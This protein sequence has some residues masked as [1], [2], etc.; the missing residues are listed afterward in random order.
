MNSTEIALQ[1]AICSGYKKNIPS[2]KRRVL[3]QKHSARRQLGNYLR[4]KSSVCRAG[5]HQSLFQITFLC[6]KRERKTQESRWRGIRG[7]SQVTREQRAE[8]LLPLCVK[9]KQVLQK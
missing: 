3:F 9:Q 6:L 7:S 8:E 4:G 1:S 5:P 2:P